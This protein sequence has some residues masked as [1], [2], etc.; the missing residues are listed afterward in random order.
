MHLGN[1]RHLGLSGFCVCDAIR[2]AGLYLAAPSMMESTVNAP[3]SELGSHSALLS[4][5]P[6]ELM[7]KQA[8]PDS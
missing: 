5:C 8:R 6:M 4:G 2:L 1:V 3:E 7:D